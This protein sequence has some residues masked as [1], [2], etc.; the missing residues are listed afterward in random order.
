MVTTN[1][2]KSLFFSLFIICILLYLFQ[3]VTHL[4]NIRPNVLLWI[5]FA[6]AILGVVVNCLSIMDDVTPSVHAYFL[7][8]MPV[9]FGLLP[10]AYHEEALG[11]IGS[12]ILM[13]VVAVAFILVAL[14]GVISHWQLIYEHLDEL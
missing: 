1:A 14:A 3:Y 12:G 5:S 6:L 11:W 10:L 8:G 4:F 13:S 9:A 2:L 7:H